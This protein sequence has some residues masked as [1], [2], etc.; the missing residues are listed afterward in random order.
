LNEKIG[1]VIFSIFI[2]SGGFMSISKPQFAWKHG[3][4]GQKSGKA[5]KFDLKLVKGIGYFL[6][7]VGIILFLS[8]IVGLIY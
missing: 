1:F 6:V 2:M 3:F 7:F 5:S 8:A 4:A